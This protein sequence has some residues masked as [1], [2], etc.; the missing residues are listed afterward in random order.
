MKNR[1]CH[2]TPQEKLE[3]IEYANMYGMGDACEKYNITERSIWRY[4]EIYDGTLESLVNKSSRPHTPHP[5]EHTEEEV[6]HIREILSKNPYISHKEL[7]EI[8]KTKYNYNRHIGGLYNYL[9]RHKMI[10]EPKQKNEYATMFDASAVNRFNKKFLY[11][12]RDRLPLYV[13]ELS[14]LGIY[15]ASNTGNYPC[16]LCA[17]YSVALTFDTIE[18]AE[19]FVKSINNTSKFELQIKELNT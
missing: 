5:S 16:K 8:L 1:N 3:I 17:Y 4:K 13:I 11:D 2:R 6:N 15:I 10:P 7:Y 12:N 14:N 18:N 9:R 19:K